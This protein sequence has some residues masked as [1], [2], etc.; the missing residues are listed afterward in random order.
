M[1][2]TTPTY[3]YVNGQRQEIVRQDGLIA[4]KLQGADSKSSA[5]TR[6]AGGLGVADFQPPAD[7]DIWPGGEMIIQ[8]APG[9][10]RSAGDHMGQVRALNERGDVA[11]ASLVFEHTPGDRWIATNQIV[12]QFT[13]SLSSY[14]LQA[15]CD[16]YN[17]EQVERIDWLPRAYLLQTT[18]AAT[19]DTVT[20]ANTL[21][22]DGH[23]LFAHPNFLRKLAH[24]AASLQPAPSLAERY[25]HL[26]AIGAFD[27][28]QI[29]TGSPD[30]AIAVIDDGVDV[31][32]EAFAK[33]SPA[34]FNAIDRSDNPRPPAD[35]VK[36]YRHGTACAGLALGSVA[37]AIGTSGVAP[38]CR[39][40]AV[41]LL[42]RV[43]PASAQQA[44]STALSGQEKL[45][46]SRA[47]SVVQPYREALAIQ[48]AAEKGAHVISNSWGPPDGKA[49]FGAVFPIDDIARLA[50]SY[51]VTAGRGG[52]G[53]II[54][55]AA[56]NGDESISVDGYASHPDVLAVAACTVAGQRAPYSDYGPE[57]GVTAPG[58]GYS[59]GLLT[60]VAVDLAGRKEY[61]HDFNGTSAATPIVAGVAALLLSKYPDLTRREVYDILKASAD[62]IDPAGGQYDS[63][64]HSPYYGFGRVNA[65]KALAEA[66]RRQNGTG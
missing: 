26:S 21:V 42:E 63:S 38:G 64:G 52:K 29:T 5:A 3:Y 39:L 35:N 9:A 6:S 49:K 55:W 23:A 41:R 54:C 66:K 30:I 27:A 50:V 2:E 34:N 53:C 24:R 19:L 11:Y 57:V 44:I 8:Q 59:D 12:A 16:F 32:H 22:E 20:L 10:T 33:R 15:L 60:T 7:A 45:A 13:E 18:P 31:D 28:W 36:N 25:W 46:L 65:A 1:A 56:G 17:L 37:Q 48:W 61:R 51:A 4:V 40:M 58:G 14:E 43:I 47:L 62:K